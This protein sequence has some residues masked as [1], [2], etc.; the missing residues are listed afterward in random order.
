MLSQSTP[1][2][3]LNFEQFWGLLHRKFISYL[4]NISLIHSFK[5]QM[6]FFFCE[7]LYFLNAKKYFNV[8]AWY[9]VHYTLLIRLWNSL[10]KRRLKAIDFLTIIPLVTWALY[11]GFTQAPFTKVH[12]SYTNAG[13]WSSP[14][15]TCIVKVVVDVRRWLSSKALS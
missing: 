1:I 4:I 7:I 6:F 15:A 13:S 8:Y 2:Y 12:A 5:V 3:W 14:S 11:S 9:L 10:W